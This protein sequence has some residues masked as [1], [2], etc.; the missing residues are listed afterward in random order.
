MTRG[1]NSTRTTVKKTNPFTGGRASDTISG[2]PRLR[3][4][5]LPRNKET[6]ALPS[7]PCLNKDVL[8]RNISSSSRTEH[9]TFYDNPNSVRQWAAKTDSNISVDFT[10]YGPA[11][12]F[13]NDL[14]MTSGALQIPGSFSVSCSNVSNVSCA[15]TN[16]FPYDGL[17]TSG[18]RSTLHRMNTGFE[19][20]Q[21]LADNGNFDF[22]NQYDGWNFSAPAAEELLYSTSAASYPIGNDGVM[23]E[24]RFTDWPSAP[25]PSDDVVPGTDFAASSRPLAWSPVSASDPSVSSSYSRNSF[26]AIQPNTPLSPIAQESA[27]SPGQNGIQEEETGFYPEFSLG[28]ALSLPATCPNAQF[29]TM[30]FVSFS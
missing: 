15:T 7:V 2:K 10:E 8:S 16:G 28:E 9:R 30:R 27:W 20:Q 4:M 3:P 24:P 12:G 6:T 22:M 19:A 25:F 5:D 23:A 17:C 18:A 26:L 21:G 1:Q 13:G 29:D 11:G 14:A